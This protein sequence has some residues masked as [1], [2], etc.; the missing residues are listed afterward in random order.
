MESFLRLPFTAPPGDLAVKRLAG[1]DARAADGAATSL[2]G[3]LA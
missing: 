1:I 2:P 3:R